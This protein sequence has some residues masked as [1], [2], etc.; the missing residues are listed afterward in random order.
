LTQASIGF[1]LSLI[2]REVHAMVV[3]ENNWTAKLPQFMKDPG[4][5]V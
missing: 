5:K 4:E 3:V 1:H 2:G